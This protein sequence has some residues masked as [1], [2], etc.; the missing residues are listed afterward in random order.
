MLAIFDAIRLIFEAFFVSLRHNMGM[1]VLA[2]GL[3]TSIWVFI[4]NEQNPPRTN[5]LPFHIPVQP[6]N[7][8]SDLDVLPNIEPVVVR[9]TAP[10]DLWSGFTES[11]FDATVDLTGAQQGSIRKA[12]S[13]KPRDARVRVLEVTP[14]LV[15]VQ[16]DKLLRR[17]VP[18]DVNIQQGPPLGFGHELPRPELQHVAVLGPE[19]LVTIV[20]AAVADVNLSG[21]RDS[22]RQSFSLEPRSARGYDI[23]GVR[24]EPSSV[25]V[26]IRIT[27]QSTYTNLP[28]VP[29]VIGNPAS[30]FWV[31][32]VRV[33]PQTVAVF[34]PPEV[35]LQTVAVRTAPIDVTNLAGTVTRQ[36]NLSAPS[37][38]TLVD[39]SAVLVEITVQPLRGNARVLVAPQVRGVAS[40]LNAR[41]EAASVEVFV[42]GEG[43]TLQ[44]FSATR[45]QVVLNVEGRGTGTYE[46]EPQ[47]DLPPGLQLERVAPTRVR[48]TVEPER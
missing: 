29:D 39:R 41:T 37:G 21:F 30:G 46:I 1:G 33:N 5:I 47:V 27:R 7:V 6:V 12:V 34:G 20:D 48:V 44:D 24:L 17:T 13:V 25:V 28:V 19:Q 11:G 18:V 23:S 9:V 42:S 35:I 31:S 40:G 14:S 32:Q 15:E 43:P 16:L 10:S 8:P 4:T 38:I 3:S 36:A 2:L 45:V 26:D 22:V